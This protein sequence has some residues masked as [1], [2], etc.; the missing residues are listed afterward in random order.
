M[1]NGVRLQQGEEGVV[2]LKELGMGRKR[3]ESLVWGQREYWRLLS[4]EGNGGR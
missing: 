3:L 2:M 4:V 1:E